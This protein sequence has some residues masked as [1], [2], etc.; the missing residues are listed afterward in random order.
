[1]GKSCSGRLRDA[2]SWSSSLL[3]HHHWKELD[4][5]DPREMMIC[6]KRWAWAAYAILYPSIP[7]NEKVVNVRGEEAVRAPEWVPFTFP[8]HSIT[9]I[10]LTKSNLISIDSKDP[11]IQITFY[12]P[13]PTDF[14]SLEKGKQSTLLLTSLLSYYFFA[15]WVNDHKW[16]YVLSS[17]PNWSLSLL[18]L[19]FLS[20][21]T[22][23][24]CWCD[25]RDKSKLWSTFTQVTERM[26]NRPLCKLIWLGFP[27]IKQAESILIFI[28]LI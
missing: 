10:T 13:P 12:P 25:S 22:D 8:P 5:R 17:F 3:L 28:L 7:W 2:S 23:W 24:W 15:K 18:H 1:M 6:L 16:K 21:L 14:I 4:E 19:S 20:S 27:S 9:S 26:T 11:F